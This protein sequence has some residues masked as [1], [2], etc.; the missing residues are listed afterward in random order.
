MQTETNTDTHRN[1]YEKC[2]RI[3]EIEACM[4]RSNIF[5]ARVLEERIKNDCSGSA[6]PMKPRQVKKKKVSTSGL[7]NKT[8]KH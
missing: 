6:N 4:Q 3:R 8:E 2:E 1:K 5:L 7:K